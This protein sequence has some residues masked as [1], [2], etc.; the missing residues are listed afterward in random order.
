MPVPAN[1]PDE[2]VQAI[3]KEITPKTKVKTS[4]GGHTGQQ[5]LGIELTVENFDG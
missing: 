3:V 2:I 1:N 4:F 5:Q